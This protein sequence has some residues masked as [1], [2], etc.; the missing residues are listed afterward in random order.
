MIIKKIYNGYNIIERNLIGLVMLFMITFGFLQVIFR[1]VLQIPVAWLEDLMMFAIVYLAYL[2]ASTA[3][4]ERKHLMI[5]MFVDML[6]D[7][8]R[9]AMT[10]FSQV[11][12]LISLLFLIYFGAQVMG[13][14]IARGTVTTGGRFPI[15]ISSMIIPIGAFLVSI[16]VIILIIQTVRGYRDTRTMK[17][18]VQEEKVS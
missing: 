1:F 6:P 3:A 10:V 18:I 8:L 17:E 9:K 15:W 11:V 5:S 4:N 13:S 14:H 12:W 16:R 2:G 7:G